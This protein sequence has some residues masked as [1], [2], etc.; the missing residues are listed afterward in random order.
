MLLAVG[1]MSSPTFWM[2]CLMRRA[3]DE[4][5]LQLFGHLRFVADPAIQDRGRV[6]EN[7]IDGQGDLPA[8]RLDRLLRRRP[9]L[10]QKQFERVQGGS[11]L[12]AEDLGELNVLRTEAA[13]LR[14]LDVEG[15]DDAIVP[16]QGDGQGAAAPLA[17]SM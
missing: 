10:H 13:G 16:F 6:G 11:E 7:V 5:L 8:D 4:D 17:P 1:A 14:A 3:A 2:L 15:A 12:A 9:L